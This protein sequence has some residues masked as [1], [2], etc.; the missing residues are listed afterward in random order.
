MSWPQ[1]VSE[2]TRE[3]CRLGRTP[4]SPWEPPSG[5]PLVAGCYVCFRAPFERMGQEQGWAAGALVRGT[6]LVATEVVTGPVN[7]PY[8]AGALA[9]RE[10]ALLQQAVLA[11]RV[12]PQVLLVNA[13]GRDHPRRAGLALHLGAVLD[14]P[15]VGV[16]HRP[17]YA[18]GI[19]PADHRGAT[20]P[21]TLDG[22]VVGYWV[23][24]RSG[25]RP[26]A[27]HAGWR[28]SAETAAQV[29]MRAVRRARTPEPVRRARF[30]ARIARARSEGPG[31]TSVQRPVE[32][33]PPSPRPDVG[34]SSASISSACSTG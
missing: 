23:R 25:A 1:D 30:A 18:D 11:F 14:L 7:A 8:Q 19:P 16:T 13:T 4:A 9:L 22:E 15:S 12:R 5:P 32:P 17:L 34:S 29:V 21:L 33:N 10:G 27:A 2:L 3:Q 28:T 31:S 24:T 20:S 26:V 6:R